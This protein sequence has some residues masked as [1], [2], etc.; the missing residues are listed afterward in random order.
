MLM[1]LLLP[2]GRC[3]RPTVKYGALGSKLL[4]EVALDGFNASE[5]ICQL[6]D[7]RAVRDLGVLKNGFPFLANRILLT[8]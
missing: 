2:G 6:C 5:L 3:L 4:I 1:L 8:L 7:V